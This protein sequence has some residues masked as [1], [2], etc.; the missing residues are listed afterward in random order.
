MF[1]IVAG[2][3]VEVGVVVS[4]VIVVGKLLSFFHLVGKMAAA[5]KFT[6]IAAVLGAL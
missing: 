6:V 2:G 3:G 5:L 4:I 1:A